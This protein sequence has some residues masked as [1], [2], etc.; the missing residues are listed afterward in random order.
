ML[1]LPLA[2]AACVASALPGHDSRRMSHD[3]PNPAARQSHASRVASHGA[4]DST[5]QA[6]FQSGQTFADFVAGATARKAWTT[7]RAAARS[8]SAALAGLKVLA[9]GFRPAITADGALLLIGQEKAGELNRGETRVLA[10][11]LRRVDRTGVRA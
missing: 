8:E 7:R 5:Y 1:T 2:F 3:R 10:E 6:L 11:F 9:N 4:A